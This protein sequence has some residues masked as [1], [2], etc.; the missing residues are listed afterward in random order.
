MFHSVL[1]TTPET[2]VRIFPAAIAAP[3]R[4]NRDVG[5][6]SAN[7]SSPLFYFYFYLYFYFLL[8]FSFLKSLKRACNYLF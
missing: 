6:D 8:I 7:E 2:R 5:R 4:S 3:S 1:R